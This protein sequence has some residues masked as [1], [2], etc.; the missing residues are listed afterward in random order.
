MKPEI[1]FQAHDSY[2]LGLRFT[3]DGRQLFSAGMDNVVKLWSVD[4][5][6]L[7]RTFSGHDKSVN[8]FAL[9][10][11]EGTLVTGSSDATVRLWDVASGSQKMVLQDRKRVVSGLSMSADGEWIAA[12]SYKGRVA[13]WTM[14]GETIAAFPAATQNI[15]AVAF[16]PADRTQLVTG[17]LGS[18]VRIWSLPQAEEV[19]S[20]EVPAVAT[21]QV[22]F[23]PDGQQ[24]IALT[25]EGTLHRWDARDWSPTPPLM[26]VTR[27]VRSL[28]L[29]SRGERCALLSEGRVQ[30]R[31]YPAWKSLLELSVDAKVLNAAAFS[32][33]GKWLVVGGADRKIRVWNLEGL[34]LS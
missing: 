24:L 15:G 13:V 23:S 34:S 32:P 21:M 11:D 28:T 20:L 27:G 29:D 16:S 30:I 18:A 31:S 22:R 33:S 4:D 6:S 9:S 2:V 14:S 17:G 7:I 26:P 25:Y 19:A 10:P 12:G 1:T 8:C 5:W 3:K